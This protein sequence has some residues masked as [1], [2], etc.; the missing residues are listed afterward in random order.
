MP[1]PIAH[2]VSGYVIF[3]FLSPEGHKVTRGNSNKK[4]VSPIYYYYMLLVNLPDFDF[5]PQ[6]LTG[7]RYHHGFTHSLVFTICVAVIW[8][9]MIAKFY[10]S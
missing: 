4:I 3:R 7:Q 8:G 6:L 9:L 1:S 10:Q 5:I 2:T